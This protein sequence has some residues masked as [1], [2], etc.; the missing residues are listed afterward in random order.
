MIDSF[1]FQIGVL[2]RKSVMM[3]RKDIPLYM[4]TDQRWGSLPYGDGNIHDCGCGPAVF[5]HVVN[6]LYQEDKINLVETCR[7]AEQMNCYLDGS[8]TLW[9]FF[10]LA[11]EKYGIKC[12]F[13]DVRNSRTID[14]VA[15]AK[16]NLMKRFPMIASM[17]PGDFTNGGHFINLDRLENDV[18][19]VFDPQNQDNSKRKWKLERVV[20]QTKGLWAF[21]R[22]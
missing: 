13:F 3:G 12:D 16:E 4:Q 5:V 14:A 15:F 21:Q 7:L 1:T 22:K 19:E 8:G 18:L 11:A 10:P 20:G 6:L 2:Y 17:R 9:K